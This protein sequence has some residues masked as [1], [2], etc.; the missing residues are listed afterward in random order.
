MKAAEQKKSAHPI[1]IDGM[2]LIFDRY[3]EDDLSWDD[4]FF[5]HHVLSVV[6]ERTLNEAKKDIDIG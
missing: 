3:S 6:H 5:L 1:V 2:Q 4:Y